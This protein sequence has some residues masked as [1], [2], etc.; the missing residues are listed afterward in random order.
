MLERNIK[1]KAYLFGDNVDTDQIYPGRYLEISKPEDIA[2]HAME[3]I[4]NNFYERFDKGSIIAAGR[5]FGLGSSREHAAI[6]LISLGV[7]L[8]IAGSFGRIFYRN[9]IN[10]GLPLMI[11]PGITGNC[12]EGN[13]LEVDLNTGMII[14]LATNERFKGEVFSDYVLKILDAGGIKPLLKQQALNM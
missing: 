9:C 2:L 7:S 6:A 13:L 10:L 1:G 12:R 14:N 11:C 3:G 5:N 4:E 8:V